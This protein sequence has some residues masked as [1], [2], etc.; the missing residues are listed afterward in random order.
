MTPTATG[1]A[2]SSRPR[3]TTAAPSV[4]ASPSA[5]ATAF[6]RVTLSWTAS[7]DNVGV[8]GYRIYRDG[9]L[10]GVVAGSVTSFAD[11]TTTGS[12][13]YSYTVAAVDA[14]G[15]ASAQSSAAGA[16]T[17]SGTPGTDT[18]APSTP[19]DSPARR[20]GRPDRSSLDRVHRQRRGR[21]LQRLSRR[22]QD[23]LGPDRFDRLFRHGSDRRRQPHL[24]G[25]RHR[26]RGQ[27]ERPE[28]EL[29]R[30]RHGQA[31]SPRPTPTTPRTA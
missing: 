30:R 28:L 4:P 3:P 12:T 24:H 7:S 19:T 17:P 1:R 29:V 16:T 20:S 27:R 25:V 23:Q 22:D 15:N 10:V 5:T 8:T 9:T 2:W 6:N 13:T 21:G 11:V 31:R 14:A 18:T 26:R